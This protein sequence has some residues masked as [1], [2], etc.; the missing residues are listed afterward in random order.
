MGVTAH[1]EGFWCPDRARSMR[2]GARI[3]GARAVTTRGRCARRTRRHASSRRTRTGAPKMHR[4][5][6]LA[7]LLGRGPRP[8]PRDAAA[9]RLVAHGPSARAFCAG[10]RF[11][12]ITSA[13]GRFRRAQRSLWPPHEVRPRR[14]QLWRWKRR[15]A[16]DT[17]GQKRGCQRLIIYVAVRLMYAKLALCLEGI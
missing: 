3:D 7:R 13:T 9:R 16:V 6:R 15:W 1:Y 14:Q 2:Q 4:Q 10:S 11:Q 12:P 8:E 5:P 17:R